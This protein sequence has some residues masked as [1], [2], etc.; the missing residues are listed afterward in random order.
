MAHWNRVDRSYKVPTT[1]VAGA[2][3]LHASNQ[4]IADRVDE[5]AHRLRVVT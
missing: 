2:L 4:A 5:F 1:Q 3:V